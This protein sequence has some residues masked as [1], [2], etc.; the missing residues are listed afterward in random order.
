MFEVPFHRW[1]RHTGGIDG[2]VT[3]VY[4]TWNH[5]V[6]KHWLTSHRPRALIITNQIRTFDVAYRSLHNDIISNLIR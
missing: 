2:S 3:V 4:I 6:D 5:V 1:S